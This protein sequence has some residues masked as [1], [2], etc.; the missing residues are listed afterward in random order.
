MGA[1]GLLA[2]WLV[3]IAGVLVTSTSLWRMFRHND[4]LTVTNKNTGK[5]VTINT[6]AGVN[7]GRKLVELMT[8]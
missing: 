4:K 1:F 6:K 8:D 7:E 2:E 3:G 5:S